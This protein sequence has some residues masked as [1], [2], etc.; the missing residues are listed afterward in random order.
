MPTK[1]EF[2]LMIMQEDQATQARLIEDLPRIG[3]GVI[4]QAHA[5]LFHVD[6]GNEV[7]SA[8]LHP[9]RVSAG[10]LRPVVGDRVIIGEQGCVEFITDVLPRRT[11]LSRSDVGTGQRQDIVANVDVVIIVVSVASPP[12]HP[13][14][15]DRYVVAIRQGGAMPALFVNK[16]DLLSGPDLEVELLQLDPYRRA[17]FPI[18]TG[19]AESGLGLD[20]LLTELKGKTAAFVGHSGVGKSSLLNAL[21]PE[22]NAET[23]LVSAAYGRG[24]HTTTSSSRHLVAP[25]TYVIDTP[26]IRSFGLADLDREDIARYFTEFAPYAGQCKYRDCLH[27][28][29]PRC[30][31]KEAVQ[32]GDISEERYGFYVQLV[33]EV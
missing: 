13:R 22:I 16:Y 11:L 15:I 14:I 32:S 24:T 6:M 10:S 20:V 17:G 3:E 23:G 5:T 7:I 19:S 31:I 12:L 18:I 28:H 8:P 33:G 2:A 1:H 21:C 4:V 30:A 29:E 26:G 9:S 25:E 27:L